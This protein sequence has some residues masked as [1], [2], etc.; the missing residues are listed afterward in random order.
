M[1][2]G[3]EW[4]E[5]LRLLTQTALKRG[6]APASALPSSVHGEPLLFSDPVLLLFS[7]LSLLMF[8]YIKGPRIETVAFHPMYN[9]CFSSPLFSFWAHRAPVGLFILFLW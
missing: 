6:A 1:F 8:L 4:A 9:F 5:P 7:N 2:M 3:Q